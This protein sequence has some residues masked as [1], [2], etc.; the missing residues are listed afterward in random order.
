M[1]EVAKNKKQNTALFDDPDNQYFG[2]TEVI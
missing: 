2:E 1:R